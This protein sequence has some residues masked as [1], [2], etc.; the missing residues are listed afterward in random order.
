MNFFAKWG[1]PKVIRILKRKPKKQESQIHTIY[2]TFLYED[3]TP[4]REE[5]QTGIMWQR[6]KF[7]RQ[8]L[9][10]AWNRGNH[11]YVWVTLDQ[12]YDIGE[13]QNWKCNRTGVPLE[14]TRG[15]KFINNTNPNSCT[16]DRINNSKGY[17]S[18]NVHLV[19]W[20]YNSMKNHWDDKDFVE[21]AKL[22]AKYS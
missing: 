17:T 10:R 16:I 6:L 4:N 5:V 22:V 2:Q 9:S 21:M 7:L 3:H 8:N 18:D 19:T 20:R 15:G 12:L 14:F 13:K 1:E 11:D